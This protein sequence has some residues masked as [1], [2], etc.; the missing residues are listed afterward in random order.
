MSIQ[1]NTIKLSKDSSVLSLSISASNRIMR[2]YIDDQDTYSGNPNIP[3]FNPVYVWASADSGNNLSLELTEDSNGKPWGNRLLFVYVVINKGEGVSETVS[4]PVFNWYNIHNIG[5]K[6]TNWVL[7]E[8]H[9][10]IPM[11]FIDFILR[12]KAFE[13][14]M[15]AGNY[16]NAIRL[17]KTY[18][19]NPSSEI[20]E[21]CCCNC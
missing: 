16:L 21:G 2:V 13:Y 20:P 9:C 4:H 11:G 19:D 6:Y 14:N 3:S 15:E 7:K 18:F 17:W 5:M 10:T 8:R 1:F 12:T